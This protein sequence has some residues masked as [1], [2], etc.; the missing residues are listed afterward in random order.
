LANNSNLCANGANQ[1]ITVNP[2]NDGS[3][4]YFTPFNGLTDLGNGS[5]KIN[6]QVM[7]AGNFN[8]TYNYKGSDNITDFSLT[9]TYYIDSIGTLDIKPYLHDDQFCIYDNAVQITG[10]VNGLEAT[11]GDFILIDGISNLTPNDGIGQF[12][13][14]TAGA[15]DHEITFI[16]PSLKTNSTCKDTVTKVLHVYDRPDITFNMP[17]IYNKTGVKDTLTASPIGGTFTGTG[18][19]DNALGVFDPSVPTASTTT[20]KYTYTDNNMCTNFLSKSIS[21]QKA[22]GSANNLKES[23]C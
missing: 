15:G 4:G 1:T 11:K 19:I 8:L 7:P 5:A 18:I 22:S 17:T 2:D 23:Y 13:P 20:I 14:T 10:Y 12:T 9:Y 16:Y 3:S 6:P 21:I